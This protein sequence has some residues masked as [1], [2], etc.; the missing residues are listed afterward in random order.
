MVQDPVV[1]QV[2]VHGMQVALVACYLVGPAETSMLCKCDFIFAALC[3]GIVQRVVKGTLLVVTHE[4]STAGGLAHFPMQGLQAS[5]CIGGVQHANVCAN[6]MWIV[7]LA[8][9]LLAPETKV[10]SS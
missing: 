10:Y 3:Y 8:S 2:S 5:G 1:Y 6:F 4:R 7:L 9:C